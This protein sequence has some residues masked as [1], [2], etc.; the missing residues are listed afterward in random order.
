MSETSV[1]ADPLVSVL[2]ACRD[3]AAYIDE[4][5]LSA[6]GQTV[7]ALEILVVDDASRD[8]TADRI[9][10]HVR[11]DRRV[12]LIQ[13]TGDGPGAARNRALAQARGAWVAVLDGDDAMHPRRLE[14]LLGEAQ[15]SGADIVLDNMLAFWEGGAEPP[16]LVMSGGPWLAPADIDLARYIE[17]NPMLTGDPALGYLK[18][19]LRRSS[20]VGGDAGVRYD[21]RLRIGEDYDLVARLLAAGAH[22]RFI[23]APLYFY[24]RRGGST[25]HRLRSEDVKAL[26][27][28]AR[29]FDEVVAAGQTEA[30]RQASADRIGML[31]Q[32]LAFTELVQA[33]KARNPAACLRIAAGAPGSLKLLAQAARE[34]LARRF[35]GSTGPKEER[36]AERLE[37]VRAPHDGQAGR[38]NA[39]APG[40]LEACSAAELEALARSCRFAREIVCEDAGLADF[41]P[42]ATLSGAQARSRT[43]QGG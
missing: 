1:E 4:A 38:L 12:R 43:A 7:A 37:L 18:P 28:Q 39:P 33:I 17:N 21:E 24:R 26:L 23:P 11:A 13:G 15:R 40:E 5:L 27:A 19:L 34:G 8:A 30:A 20:L 6:R 35:G 10:A 3:V 25:S 29:E 42:Y 2:V 36:S 31:K 32:I 9:G 16:S 22:L 14:L 41:L